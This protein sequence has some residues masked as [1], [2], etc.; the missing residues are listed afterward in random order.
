MTLK[1]EDIGICWGS[2][3][4]ASL[5]ELMSAAAENGFSGI[6]VSPSLYTK[7][8]AQGVS[9]AELRLR[10]RDGGIKVST[11]DPL[12][13]GLPGI[14]CLADIPADL[15][16]FFEF[17]EDDCHR[18]ADALEAQSIN[19]AH[20]LGSPVP[21]SELADALAHICD[22]A[23]ERGRR[24][25]FE[26]I[27][28]TGSPN[29]ASAV[30]LLSTAGRESLELT[31]DVWHLARSGGTVDDIRQLPADCVGTL[32]LCDRSTPAP[33]A[34]YVPMS[35]RLLPGEGELALWELVGA[36][37][38]ISPAARIELEV[39]SARLRSLTP[40][41]AGREIHSALR[42]WLESTQ[43]PRARN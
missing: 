40:A 16:A 8:R 13:R 26:F 43:P 24:V 42:S 38:E 34:H 33:S 17:A 20:F 15:C 12:I 6:T 39:F 23:A 36:V 27:P 11:I 22:R 32:Q 29:L 30:E 37:R 18:I 25:L 35:D 14:P 1:P 7:A 10:L 21:P 5:T 41:D 28:G 3:S 4:Q 9:D 31:V 2:I 19:V